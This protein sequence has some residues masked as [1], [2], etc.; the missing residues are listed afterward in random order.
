MGHVQIELYLLGGMLD[1]WTICCT[2]HS[3]YIQP[4]EISWQMCEVYG[5]NIMS[6]DMVKKLVRILND[7]KYCEW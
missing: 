7:G 4:S 5:D 6:D 2:S 1:D 3:M